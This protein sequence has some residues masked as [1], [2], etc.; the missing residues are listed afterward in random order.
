MSF[1]KY[2]QLAT[3]AANQY[4][5]DPPLYHRLIKQE[6]NWNPG[7][8]SPV[9]ARGLT[10][11]MPATAKEWKVDFNDPASQINKGAEY[12]AYLRDYFDGDMR[13]A[14]ASYN[15]G[16]GNVQKKGLERMPEETRNYVSKIYDSAQPSPDEQMM[17]A[18]GE[19]GGGIDQP[20]GGPGDFTPMSPGQTIDSIYQNNSAQP[21][22]PTQPMP[23]VPAQ[24]SPYQPPSFRSV[25]SQRLEDMLWQDALMEEEEAPPPSMGD[26]LGQL[27]PMFMSLS[28]V[29]GGAQMMMQAQRQQMEWRREQKTR[30][31]A[32][33][34]RALQNLVLLEDRKIT[35]QNQQRVKPSTITDKQGNI[36]EHT[37]GSGGAPRLLR[38]AGPN[39]QEMTKEMEVATAAAAKEKQKSEEANREIAMFDYKEARKALPAIKKEIPK[40]KRSAQRSKEFLAILEAK[41]AAGESITGPADWFM[42]LQGPGGGKI[43]QMY[44]EMSSQHMIDVLGGIPG[45]AS[46]TDLMEARR[47]I[48]NPTEF[49]S[50][51]KGNDERLME[52]ARGQV[53]SS[54]EALRYAEEYGVD[55][56]QT[57]QNRG[58]LQ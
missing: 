40:F 1:E 10:Q 51:F 37:P 27:A 21:G 9:G 24:Q 50:A 46:D 34:S 32:R 43:D 28:G 53:E 16:M 55:L 54:E 31:R 41:K 35:N 58:A 33:R 17:M 14:V 8:V 39:G 49:F 5:I 6:S 13:K 7:A 45:A 48:P 29:P 44:K 4:G 47:P 56:E 38:G 26:F 25:N 3:D 23:G 20:P 30:S 2:G 19:Q 36:W 11:F 42:T 22:V 52:W 15:W 18:G 57:I 12:L